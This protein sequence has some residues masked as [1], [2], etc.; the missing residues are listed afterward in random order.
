MRNVLPLTLCALMLLAFTS[1]ANAKQVFE[2]T[3][4]KV[5]LSPDE[6]SRRAG[7]KDF[8]DTLIFKGGKFIS[9]ACKAHG[10]QPADY[11]ENT[12][13]GMVGA[14]KATATSAKEGKAEWHGNATVNQLDGEMTW[15]KA[16]GS[17]IRYTFKGDKSD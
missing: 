2:G 17:V 12:R 14:F 4:W 7:A 3:K 16:D 1:Q 9:E 15:T 11:E 8:K 5:V 10:F 13:P 6:D